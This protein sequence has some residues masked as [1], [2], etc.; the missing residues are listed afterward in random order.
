M[1]PKLLTVTSHTVDD[2]SHAMYVVTGRM[3]SAVTSCLSTTV[4]H[5][6]REQQKRAHSALLAVLCRRRHSSGGGRKPLLGLTV[7]VGLPCCSTICYPCGSG[8]ACDFCDGSCNSD[9]PTYCDRVH[10]EWDDN[11]NREC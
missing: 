3:E 8:V 9:G 2:E 6:E 11:C 4:K 10:P 7:A 1:R 5:R